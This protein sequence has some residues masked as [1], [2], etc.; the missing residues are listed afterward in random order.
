M[1]TAPEVALKGSPLIEL[2]AQTPGSEHLAAA[3]HAWLDE[4]KASDVVMIDVRGKSSVSD[5][6]LIATGRTDRH[7]GAIAEQVQKKLKQQGS[8]VLHMEG[9]SNCDWVL[10]D[11]GDIVVH[12]FRPEVRE[13]YNLEKLWSGDRPNEAVEH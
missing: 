8:R 11:L 5:Y 13:F 3:I 1:R 12:V 6:M 2:R 7:V 4:A 10:M 9:L